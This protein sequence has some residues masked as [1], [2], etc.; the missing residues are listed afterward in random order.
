MWKSSFE[1]PLSPLLQGII[2]SLLILGP[3][4]Q[5]VNLDVEKNTCFHLTVFNPYLLLC[6]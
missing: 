3:L 6:M 5:S 4:Q 1:R 2:K